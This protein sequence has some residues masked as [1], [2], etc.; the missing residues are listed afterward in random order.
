MDFRFSQDQEML[1]QSARDYLRHHAPLRVAR[2]VLESGAPYDVD[3]WQGV[4]GLGVVGARGEGGGVGL[5]LVE[6]DGAG[7]TREPLAS[8]D[9]TRP[10][11]RLRFDGAPAEPLGDERD[12]PRLIERLLDRAA[13]LLAFEQLGA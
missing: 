5:A 6:L 1:R 8:I 7:V 9:P 3:L 12:A 13:V 10:Q 4:A 2:A 11:A